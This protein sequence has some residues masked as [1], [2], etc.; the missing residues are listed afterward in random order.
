MFGVNHPLTKGETTM[1]NISQRNSD[2]SGRSMNAGGYG[3]G[4]LNQTEDEEEEEQ[5]GHDECPECSG[6]V[7]SD[8]SH[9]ETSCVDC[10]LVIDD[11]QI[12]HGPE[13][14]A[15]NQSERNQKK[16]TGSPSTEMMH[17]KGLSTKISWED[18]DA[19]GRSLSGRQKQKMRRL[20]Q[21]DERSRAKDSKERNLKQA[22]GEINRMCSALGI[23]KNVRETSSVIYQQCLEN[24]MIRG[25]SIEAMASAS[26]HGACRQAGIPRTM[27]DVSHVS[28]VEKKRISR[29]YRYISRELGLSIDPPQP[30]GYIPQVASDVKAS[31]ETR[32]IAEKMLTELV[33]AGNHSGKHPAGLAAS[34]L[35]AADQHRGNSGSSTDGLTQN[36]MANSVDV[37]EVTIR[38]RSEEML[39]LVTDTEEQVQTL[40]DEFGMADET[41]SLA[42]EILSDWNIGKSGQSRPDVDAGVALYTAD[43]F[44]QDVNVTKEVVGEV[45]DKTPDTIQRRSTDMATSFGLDI[46]DYVNNMA[47]SIDV[48]DD[49]VE[50]A[51]EVATSMRSTSS[52]ASVAASALYATV[53]YFDSARVHTFSECADVS[54]S[55]IQQTAQN[56]DTVLNNMFPEIVVDI[57]DGTKQNAAMLQFIEDMEALHSFSNDIDMPFAP[58]RCKNAFVATEEHLENIDYGTWHEIEGGLYINTKYRKRD[59]KS[60]MQDIADVCGVDVTFKGW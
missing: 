2:K 59:K 15:Y 37:C 10:G 7:I 51:V 26:I 1:Q 22:L 12:D 39:E 50:T 6:Q 43:T 58:G 33:E 23:P 41:V 29:A 30:T 31:E 54:V 45:V 53:E 19:Y 27:D 60:R 18:R 48:A 38:N 47:D 44:L 24:D 3:R 35:Y 25:R 4:R 5:T 49:H 13:W 40:G 16:R 32:Q 46:V 52:P 55:T 20:R 17:D 9:G 28:R 42:Q 34:A 21:W 56:A 8:A 36:Q 11:D 57:T 14:R